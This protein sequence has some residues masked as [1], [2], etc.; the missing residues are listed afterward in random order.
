MAKYNEILIGRWN[1]MLQKVTG[2]KGGPV[3]AQLS[4]D[5]QPV[6]SLFSGVEHR[7]LESWELFATTVGTPQ[8]AATLSKFRFRNPPNSNVVAVIISMHLTQ[9]ITAD[10]ANRMAFGAVSTDLTTSN[11]VI[12]RLDSRGRA[13]PTC[14]S[15]TEQSVG[16]AGFGQSMATQGIGANADAFPVIQHSGSEI[17]VLPGDGFQFTASVVNAPFFVSLVWRERFLEDSERT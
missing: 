17:P 2:I 7:Y 16:A 14:L 12:A 15:S 1:R 10:A 13:Q 3:A 6:I 8:G 11:P 5:I 9:G 4:S